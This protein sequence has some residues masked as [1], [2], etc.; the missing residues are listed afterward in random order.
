M[1]NLKVSKNLPVVQE[2]VDYLQEKGFVVTLQHLKFDTPQK[3]TNITSP[4]SHAT[5]ITIYPPDNRGIITGSSACIEEDN[6][7]RD[8]GTSIAF[9]RALSVLV[10]HYPTI[11]NAN[12]L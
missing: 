4:V 10:R 11:F 2:F 12:T 6:F 3:Y 1:R 9:F 7:N 8:I 5:T